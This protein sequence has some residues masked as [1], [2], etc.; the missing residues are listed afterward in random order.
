LLLSETRR[1]RTQSL[2]GRQIHEI[3]AAGEIR[4]KVLQIPQL[5]IG[6]RNPSFIL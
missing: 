2:S 6:V 4:T 1:G 5:A 3:N